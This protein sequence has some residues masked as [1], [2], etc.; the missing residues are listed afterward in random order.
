VSTPHTSLISGRGDEAT[1]GVNLAIL[2][3]QALTVLLVGVSRVAG[4]AA[5]LNRDRWSLHVCGVDRGVA[6]IICHEELPLQCEEGAG[7]INL[8]KGE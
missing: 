3:C 8:V 1:E 2:V 6:T 4:Q 7:N 5:R